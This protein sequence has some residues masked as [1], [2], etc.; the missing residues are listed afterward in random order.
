MNDIHIIIISGISG[1]GKS[2]ALKTLEDLGFFC[3]DNLP[4]TLIPPFCELIQRSGEQLPL[5]ALVIDAREDQP[6]KGIDLGTEEIA[7]PGKQA[8]RLGYKQVDTGFRNVREIS[9]RRLAGEMPR[10]SPPRF[11]TQ[12]P[13]AVDEFVQVSALAFHTFSHH[14]RAQ[15]VSVTL[16]MLVVKGTT[17]RLGHL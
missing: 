10:L 7:R 2:T 3:V 13:D 6:G 12:R 8:R 17:S 14:E 9:A 4:V 11:L 5:A 15:R 1:S 16:A